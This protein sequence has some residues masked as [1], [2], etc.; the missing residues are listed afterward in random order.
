MQQLFYL[1]IILKLGPFRLSFE[2]KSL[3]SPDDELQ[4]IF[5]IL[6]GA[7]TPLQIPAVAC[8][9][10]TISEACATLDLNVVQIGDDGEKVEH[11][12]LSL[13]RGHANDW[14]S[15]FELVRDLV[16]QALTSDAGGLA[17]VN[18]VN[19][20]PVEIIRYDAGRISVGYDGSGSGELNYSL[21]G[22]PAAAS[23]IIHVRGPFSKCPASLARDAIQTAA[24]METHTNRLFRSGARPGGVVEVPSTVKLDETAVRNLR[25]SFSA[26]YEGADKA[27]RTAFLYSGATFKALQLSSVDAQFLELRRFVI[28]EIARAFN[29]PVQML[30]DLTKSSYANAAQK[31]LEFLIY[32]LEP[33]LCA[34]ESAFNRALLTA[35]ERKTLTFKFDR[36]DLSRASLTDRANAINSLRASKVLNANE[37][38]AWLGLAPYDGGE[39]Y[40]NTNI[41]TPQKYPVND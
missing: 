17:W 25:S 16:A 26:A 41:T 20:R 38:R 27:G 36:D 24:V 21:N 9:V 28:E 8:A 32:C 30:G 6:P 2:R 4:Q 31:Q 18:R 14:T 37:G 23:D 15:G 35:D 19:T 3:A 11:P 10:R 7:V 29:M 39:V 22:K 13:L 5:G 12:A 34:L 40:E 33:W 1:G